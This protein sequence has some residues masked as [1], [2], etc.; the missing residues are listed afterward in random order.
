MR[1][2]SPLI[3]TAKKGIETLG[4][5]K[6]IPSPN[7]IIAKNKIPIIANTLDKISITN[8]NFIF[9]SLLQIRCHIMAVKQS[10]T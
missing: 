4:V 2:R 1:I 3:K 9:L 7:I 5:L 6:E 8:L 10:I